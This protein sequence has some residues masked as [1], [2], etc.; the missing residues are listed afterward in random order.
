[1]F[2]GHFAVGLAAKPLAPRASL[3]VLLAAPQVLD[4]VWPVLVTAGVE[5]VRIVPGITAASPL[6]LDDMP[7]S[8][9]LVMAAVWATVFTIG[10]VAWTRDRRGAPVMAALVLSHWVLDWIAHRPDMQLAPGVETRLGLG[11]WNSVPGTLFVETAMFVGGALLYTRS[12][13]ARDRIGGAGFWI[14]IAALTAMY[15]GAVLGPPPPSVA[16]M[17]VLSFASIGVLGVAWWIDRHR[18]P[19]A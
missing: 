5:H 4:V 6:A 18:E 10:Y 13:R 12:T 17:M 9:S 14:L 19:R 1:M 7:Y 8:H 16:A 11:L 3:P 2:I 15:F